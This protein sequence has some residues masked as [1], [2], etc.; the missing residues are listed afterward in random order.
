[1]TRARLNWIELS[2]MAFGRSSFLTSD[3]ISDWYSGAAER[4]GAAGDARQRQDVP[5]P[6]DVPVDQ[7][8]QGEGGG[9]L[10]PLRHQQQPAPVAAVGHDAADQREQHDR[11]LAEEGVEPQEERRFGERQNEPGLGDAL[12]PGA[13]A[14]GEGAEPQDAEIPVGE[15]GRQA[16]EG[17]AG[18]GRRDRRVGGIG[19]ERV[20]QFGPSYHQAVSRI[21]KRVMSLAGMFRPRR[22]RLQRPLQRRER[23]G[24]NAGTADT[25]RPD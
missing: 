16:P 19:W 13:D 18:R 11:Q 10:D 12:H 5:D 23:L 8:G 15:R 14:G 1:M 6:H 9:H 24:G 7:A 21:G 17:P 25:R 3:G 4:L 2:A 22:P 20:G